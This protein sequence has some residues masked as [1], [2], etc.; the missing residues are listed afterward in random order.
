MGQNYIGLTQVYQDS[1]YKMVESYL[2]S[3]NLKSKVFCS[4]LSLG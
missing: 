4:S 3:S 1:D 2:T